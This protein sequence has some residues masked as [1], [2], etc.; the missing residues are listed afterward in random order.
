M[1]FVAAQASLR[2]PEYP[3]TDAVSVLKAHESRL[4]AYISRRCRDTS[5]SEDVIFCGGCNA[6]ES[7]TVASALSSEL[8]TQ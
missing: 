8:G 3:M 1:W 6:I 5:R 4:L 2:I 7:Q